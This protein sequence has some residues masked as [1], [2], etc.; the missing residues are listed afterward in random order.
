MKSRQASEIIAIICF[1]RK[2]NISVCLQDW[3]WK[4]TR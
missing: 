4:S 2:V 3:V 1:S